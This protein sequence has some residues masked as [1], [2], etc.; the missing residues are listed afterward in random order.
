[1]EENIP[2]AARGARGTT[3]SSSARGA[4]RTTPASSLGCVAKTTTTFPGAISNKA[5]SDRDAKETTASSEARGAKGTTT[6]SPA[7]GAIE[8]I[9]SSEARGAKGTKTA[10]SSRGAK[11]TTTLSLARGAIGT[12]TLSPA[13]GAK[14]TTASSPAQTAKGSTALSPGRGAQR[15]TA[16]SAARGAKGTKTLLPA[17]GAKGTTILSPTR[18][19]KGTTT[20]SLARG[21]KGTT[22]SSVAREAKGTKTLSAARETKET[23]TLFSRQ[24]A[25]GT[26]TLSSNQGAKGTFSSQGAKQTKY[27]TSSQGVEAITSSSPSQVAKATTSASSIQG[28]KASTSASSI[29]KSTVMDGSDVLNANTEAGV[30]EVIAHII[31]GK[32]DI[33]STVLDGSD[34]LNANTE[35]CV[36]EVIAHTIKGKEDIESTVLDGSDVLNAN[37]EA[38][39]REVIAHTI[40]GKK[41]IESSVLDG[42]E[43]LSALVDVAKREIQDSKTKVDERNYQSQCKELIGRTKRLYGDNLNQVTISPLNDYKH[44][45]LGNVYMPPKIVHMCEANG[46]FKKTERHVTQYKDVFFKDDKVNPRIFLQG[47]AGSGKTTFLAK[48]ALEWCRESHVSSASDNSSLF[49]NDVDVVQSFVFVFYITLRNSVKQF[50]VYKLIKEQIIDSIYSSHEDREQAYRLLNEI[51]KRERCLVLLDGLDEWTGPG[52]HHNLPTL[53]LEQSQCVLLFSTRPWKL[54]VVKIMHLDRYTSVHLEGINK[55]FEFS[56]IILSCLV[57]K[58]ELELKYSAFEQYIEKQELGELLSSPMM[59]SAIVCSYAEGIEL[60]GSKCEIYT[61]LVESLFK[62]ANSNT[63]P[64]QQPPFPCFIRTEYIQPNLEQLNCLAEM[65]FHLLFVNDKEHSIMFNI[66]ESLKKLKIDEYKDFA[67]KSGILSAQRTASAL[68]SS[69]SFMFIHL[70]MQE[71]LAAYHIARNTNLID[72]S[73]SVYLNRHPEA[74]LE[75]SQVFIFLCGLDVSCAEKLSSMMDE[76]YALNTLPLAESFETVYTYSLLCSQLNEIILAGLREANANGYSDIALKLSHFIFDNNNIID[77]HKIWENN[78]A[79]AIVLKVDIDDRKPLEN[80]R[81]SPGNDECASQITFDLHSCLEL[82]RLKL[83]GRCILGNGKYTIRF[84]CQ[85]CFRYV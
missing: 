61:L 62:K 29:M 67:L 83:S 56:R 53:V 52:N 79:N 19:A 45:Q 59:L 1:M 47:E 48:L 72:G 85:M 21:A 38:G 69:S 77:L 30:R 78:A 28:V 37:T 11:G 74:Y 31:K 33:E 64:F 57:D 32:E 16:L 18:G 4:K 13:R 54:T 65:A 81:I 58:D 36:Q 34:V 66:T 5:S 43:E 2:K 8:T 35:A 14:E 75:I 17:R 22:A 60:K 40:K 25:I 71:F 42:R 10:L 49:F 51:M 80:P 50:D 27:S 26:K 70:S 39:V 23:T 63:C 7:R 41:N 55:P 9:A 24:G 20:L 44:E 73:I 12:T 68:R 82:A 3:A 76:R 46:V 84:F 6:L 15:T